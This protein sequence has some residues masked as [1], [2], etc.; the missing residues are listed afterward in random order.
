MEEYGITYSYIQYSF[1]DYKF[2]NHI[3]N[4]AK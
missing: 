3:P 4:L 2:Q 1:F